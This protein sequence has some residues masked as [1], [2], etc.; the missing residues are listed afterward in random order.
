M[1]QK[2]LMLWCFA[3]IG[4]LLI[5]GTGLTLAAPTAPQADP[6]D[7]APPYTEVEMAKRVTPMQPYIAGQFVAIPS[8]AEAIEAPVKTA[9]TTAKPK[10]VT[11][12]KDV[13]TTD[14]PAGMTYLGTFTLTAYCPC[15][16][17]CGKAPSNPAYGYTSTGV[18]ATANHTI[19]VDPHVIPYGTTVYING[20]AYVAEDCGGGVH[21]NRIDIFFDSHQAALNFGVQKSK[22]YIL[23]DK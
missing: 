23:E 10:A 18:K 17:C 4:L 5:F 21:K 14:A 20:Q 8:P 11:P 6:V 9:V 7:P 16:K 22:I 1:K 3:L 19:A 2:T 13:D 15:Q 12:P